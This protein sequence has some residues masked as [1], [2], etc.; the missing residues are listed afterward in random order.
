[1]VSQNFRIFE[2]CRKFIPNPQ[3]N[4]KKS[5]EGMIIVCVIILILNLLVLK[6]DTLLGS[7]TFIFFGL[8]ALIYLIKTLIESF[9]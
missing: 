1:M 9:K 6:Y 7:L 5:N 8:W 3:K 4:M 2:R